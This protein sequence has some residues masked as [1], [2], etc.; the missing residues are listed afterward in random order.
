[1]KTGKERREGG[2]IGQQKKTKTARILYFNL[3][4]TNNSGKGKQ[5]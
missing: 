4:L 2:R 5:Q 3:F 1:M